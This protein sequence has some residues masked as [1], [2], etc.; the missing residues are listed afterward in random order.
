LSP[1]FEDTPRIA[2]LRTLSGRTTLVVTTLSAVGTLW[3]ILGMTTTVLL[4]CVALYALVF[5]PRFGQGDSRTLVL[6]VAG[7]LGVVVT[8]I[9]GIAFISD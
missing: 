8:V 3:R 1:T 5:N 6:T 9:L 4:C 2:A 7:V